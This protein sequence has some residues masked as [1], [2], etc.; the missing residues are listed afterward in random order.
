MFDTF[1]E[2]ADRH[3]LDAHCRRDIEA[4]LRSVE[5]DPTVPAPQ[6]TIADLLS[7]V[8]HTPQG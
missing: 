6:S 7:D 5:I 4:L 1:A 2:I 3:K 8:D